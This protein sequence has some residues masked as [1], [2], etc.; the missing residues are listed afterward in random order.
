M[1]ETKQK[2]K[3]P[4]NKAKKPVSKNCPI[5]DGKRLE[6]YLVKCPSTKCNF[7]ACRT[8]TEKYLLSQPDINPK[9]MSCRIQWDQEFLAQNTSDDFHNKRYRD[10][11]AKIILE[12]EKSLLPATQFLAFEKK[13]EE[14]RKK[15]ADEIL[16]EIKVFK[17]IVFNLE[18]ERR[19]LLYYRQ[20]E[21]KESKQ[22]HTFVGHCPYGSCKGYLNSEHTCGLCEKKACRSCR[23]VRHKGECDKDTVETVK[24]L[25]KEC[26]QCPGCHAPIHK[27]EGC[28][29]IFC[30]HEDTPIWMWDGSKK[31][32]KDIKSGD[33]LIGDD[34][35][36]RIVD[37]L[38]SGED[39]LYEVKQKYGD[40]YK[41]IGNHL[42]TLEYENSR[43]LIDISV[44]DYLKYEKTL[45]NICR[46]AYCGRINWGSTETPQTSYKFGLTCD[47]T[48]IPD[49]Y[50]KTYDRDYL[51]RGILESNPNIQIFEG[52]LLD[53]IRSLGYRTEK[54]KII[55]SL[56][57]GST[58]YD[59]F[60]TD[61]DHSIQITPCGRGKYNGWSVIGPTPR[62]LLGDGTITHNCT[63]CHTAFS[64]ST[65]KIETGRIHNP[66]YYEWLRKTGNK[67]REIGDVRCGGL[68]NVYVIQDKIRTLLGNHSSPEIQKTL[69]DIHRMSG[70]V[71]GVILPRYTLQDAERINRDLRISYLLGKLTEK[72]WLIELKKREK[73]REKTRAIYQ[74]LIMFTDTVDD[75]LNN[76]LNFDTDEQVI[77]LAFELNELRLYVNSNLDKIS[78]RFKNKVPKIDKNWHIRDIGDR[79][80]MKEQL[81]TEE[82]EEGYDSETYSDSEDEI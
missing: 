81:D 8:C 76:I 18:N 23:Q 47:Y 58:N 71:R 20:D 21:N 41:V 39:E 32:A 22:V 50:L 9:C 25:T 72:K 30:Q 12:R 37:K 51:L 6:T 69:L 70:H 3:S 16:K 77:N 64:W 57:F 60:P 34:G 14:K 49:G 66:H 63:N 55:G 54:N 40:S 15:K 59:I 78:K 31:K 44:I 4:K 29:Q 19:D 82:L 79:I 73:A 38:T 56:P 74:V 5:C 46:S 43:K 61:T 27:T 1:S 10:Y 26:R 33:V 35:S 42:L 2:S 17:E 45:K 11:V 53:L 67:E 62:Y 75:L 28:D 48:S 68:A 24:L 36:P 52:K 65:G 7:E 13:E 80:R